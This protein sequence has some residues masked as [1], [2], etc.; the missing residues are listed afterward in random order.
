MKK[1]SGPG[2]RPRWDSDDRKL[3]LGKKLIRKFPR[4]APDKIPL[5]EE[6]EKQGWPPRIDVRDLVPEGVS[7]KAW[8]KYTVENMNRD[9]RGRGLRFHGSGTNLTVGWGL[10]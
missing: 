7:G 10:A 6:F 3:W 8:V 2:P 4:D 5:L 1:S 9:I